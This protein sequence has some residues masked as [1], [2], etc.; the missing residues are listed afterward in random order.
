MFAALLLGV[1]AFFFFREKDSTVPPTQN[2]QP[3]TQDSTKQAPEVPTQPVDNQTP[4]ATDDKEPAENQPANDARRRELIALA[5][6]S[7]ELPTGFF[8]D[9]LKSTDG[10]AKSPL[11][12]AVE[13]LRQTPPDYQKAIAEFS[14]IRPTEHQEEYNKAQEMLAHAYFKTGQYG[15]AAVIFQKRT[16]MGLPPA[17]HDEAEWYLLLSLIPDYD[18]QK[19]RVDGLL[20]KMAGAEFHEY[21]MEAVEMGKKL[22]ESRH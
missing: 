19:G 3:T 16:E 20:K 13:A 9:N 8:P 15:K 17:L 10:T 6:A 7:H 12:P 4:I 5:D 21:H 18:R 2:E 14:K 22:A 11:A 1:A